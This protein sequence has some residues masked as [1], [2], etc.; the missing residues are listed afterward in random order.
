MRRCYTILSGFSDHY[1]GHYRHGKPYTACFC[2]QSEAF[3]AW[4]GQ[5]IGSH[6]EEHQV[7]FGLRGG[8]QEFIKNHLNRGGCCLI[9]DL[10]AMLSCK[11]PQILI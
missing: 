9:K 7:D 5:G 11:V 10:S 6:E 3:L 8:G 1:Q 2:L 4:G